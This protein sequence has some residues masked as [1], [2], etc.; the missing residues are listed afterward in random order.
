[1]QQLIDKK[2]LNACGGSEDT[3]WRIIDIKDG[4]ATRYP[5]I[6]NG[7]EILF[8][9]CKCDRQIAEYLKYKTEVVYNAY[10]LTVTGNAVSCEQYLIENGYHAFA[11]SPNCVEIYRDIKNVD[12]TVKGVC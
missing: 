6:K 4:E 1:M 8:T 7:E 3:F 10:I 9:Q 2:L 5:S 12:T 11:V